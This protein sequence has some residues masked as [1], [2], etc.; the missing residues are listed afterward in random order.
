MATAPP[1]MPG[2]ASRTPPCHKPKA[3][4]AT[5]TTPQIAD[6]PSPACC[7]DGG[8]SHDS[9]QK[10]D[11]HTGHH[12]GPMFGNDQGLADHIG[13]PRQKDNRERVSP[14][15]AAVEIGDR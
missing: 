7:D 13:D 14:Y 9:E 6:G 1:S 10:T 4:A 5:I 8:D 15:G 12:L 11:D 2:A 3:S